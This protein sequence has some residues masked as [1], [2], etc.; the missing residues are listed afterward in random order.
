MIKKQTVRQE[1]FLNKFQKWRNLSLFNN[2]IE[3]LINLQ[4]IGGEIFVI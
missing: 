1:K 3:H 4:E 2:N